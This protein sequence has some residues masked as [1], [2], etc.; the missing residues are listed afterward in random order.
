MLTDINEDSDII[1]GQ[2]ELF[3][4]WRCEVDKGQS[5]QRIDKYLAEHMAGTSRHRIQKAGD[6]G[7]VWVNGAPVNNNYK[8]KPLDLIQVLLDHEPNDYTIHPENIP[9]NVVYEDDDVLVVN[10]PAGMVVHPGHGN[11]D[12]T[13]LN[14][15][16]W[17]FRD[18]LDMNDPSIGLRSEERRVG[19]ECLRLCRSRWSPYH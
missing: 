19:K 10:K 18:T 1:F 5:P 3:E 9:L 2:E 8:V 11:Y 6:S 13:L 16:A 15:L 14:A 7:N 4:R 12:H 17:Y